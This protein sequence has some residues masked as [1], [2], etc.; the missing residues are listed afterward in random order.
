MEE[1][2]VPVKA[3]SRQ[4][5]VTRFTMLVSAE[6]RNCPEKLLVP[7]FKYVRSVKVEIEDGTLPERKL[8]FKPK[9]VSLDKL[10]IDSGI[11]PSNS[12]CAKSNQVNFVRRDPIDDGKVPSNLLSETSSASRSDMVAI[13]DGIVPVN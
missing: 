8:L 1:G 9:I 7:I 11:S 13:S 6:N 10:E 5:N 2:M 3:F 12:L 4:S